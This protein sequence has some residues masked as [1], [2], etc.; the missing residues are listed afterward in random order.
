MC[1]TEARYYLLPFGFTR[2]CGKEV[3]INELGD[4]LVAPE[5]TVSSLVNRTIER[6]DLYKSLMANFFVSA[7]T[8][9]ALSGLYAARL[10]ARKSFLGDGPSLHIFVLTL[11]CN[12]N[13]R[14][15][16]ASSRGSDSRGCTMSHETLEQA[17]RLMM[18]SP[19]PEVTMEFQGGEPSLEPELI[20]KAVELAENLNRTA[21]KTIH[22]VLCT[23]CVDLSPE[24]LEMCAAHSIVISTSLDGPEWLHNANRGR[25][26]SHARVLAGI[27]K[28]RRAL[29]PDKVSALMT[30]SQLSLDH[31]R[32][33]V[34]EYRRLGFNSIFLRALNPYG[35][36]GDSGNQ[37]EYT[38]RFIEFYKQALDYIIDINRAGAFFVE[39]FAS[40]VLRKILTPAASGFVDLQSPAGIIN[41]VLVY[42]Y[43]GGVYCSDESRM[44]AEQGDEYFR[45]GITADS[46]ESLVYGRRAKE[47]A[48]VWAA[49]A[50]A[51]CSDCALRPYCGADPVRAYSTQ[52]DTYGFRPGSLQCLKHKAI[53]EHIISLII[54]RGD[55]VLPVFT[56][57]TA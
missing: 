5:G 7:E 8:P 26:D 20:R 13:C 30:A 38:L 39:E 40:I 57:W 35:L 22:Y 4:M 16:H 47:I 54:K 11:R 19:S 45:L 55:E 27:E 46:Y 6:G 10:R 42:N 41:S 52:G 56:S 50:L 29:G 33:I 18:A 17:V 48:R 23:N 32:E 43:D 2:L 12:Q 44:L 28:A 14:Y 1:T 24:L 37:K 34:D 15:C 3:L 36:A 53:I 25:H 51:G 21:G 31:P 9:P 49:E